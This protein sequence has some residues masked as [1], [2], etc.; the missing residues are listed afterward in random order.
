MKVSK[1]NLWIAGTDNQKNKALRNSGGHFNI[2]L[3]GGDE[4]LVKTSAHVITR[5]WKDAKM[6]EG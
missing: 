5:T 6:L 4:S 3:G 1:S 2:F